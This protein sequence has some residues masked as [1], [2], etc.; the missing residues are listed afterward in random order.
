[1]A[2]L[3]N[4]LACVFDLD[5]SVSEVSGRR[6][7]AEA[8]ARRWLTPRGTLFYAPTYGAGLITYLHGEMQSVEIRVGGRLTDAAGPFRFVLSVSDLTMDLVLG[9]S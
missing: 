1:M 3:G 8:I 2:D 7:L 9:V 4:D 5:P 6:A